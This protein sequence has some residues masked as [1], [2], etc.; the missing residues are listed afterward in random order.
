MQYELG[1]YGA[2]LLASFEFPHG[3][4]TEPELDAIGIPTIMGMTEL[5]DGRK[6]TM[7]MRFTE[8]D[9]LKKYV[10]KRAVYV[11]S[12]NRSL[13][14]KVNQHQFDALVC[15]CFNVGVRA[16]ENES[17]N[18]VLR[19]TN[20]GE[21]ENAAAAFGKWVYGTL[22]GGELGPDGTLARG[23]DGQNLLPGQIWK[24]AFAGLY[25]RHIHEALLYCSLDGERAAHP[26]NI[27]LTKRTTE[28]DFGYYDVVKFKTPWKKI[29]DDAKYDNLPLDQE[30][31]VMDDDLFEEEPA[32]GAVK[33][34]DV[35]IKEHKELPPRWL[36]YQSAVAAKYSGTY[37]EF[38]AHRK[39]VKAHKG[40][41]VVVPEAD[42]ETKLL[43]DSQTVDGIMTKRIGQ[44]QAMV[45]TATTTATGAV[46]AVRGLTDTTR[47]MTTVATDASDTVLSLSLNQILITLLILGIAAAAMGGIRWWIGENKAYEGRMRDT[48][49]KV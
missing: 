8:A 2:K 26:D 13:R 29:K 45:A 16:F 44:R 33:K 35:S 18:S 4:Q 3:I 46:A 15:M 10:A 1:Y 43:E 39:T 24:K 36:E 40:K 34:Y 5:P 11:H 27:Q 7:D 48:V 22:R 31:P 14:V 42:G 32:P 23:P 28:R 38:I 41:I 19:L 25:R 9:I 6:V 21:F 20:K 17:G 37:D 30:E 12:V 49:P 47:E